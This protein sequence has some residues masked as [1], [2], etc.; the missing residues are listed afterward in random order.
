MKQT[1]HKLAQVAG[2]LALLLGMSQPAQAVIDGIT[3]PTFNLKAAPGYISTA[4]GNNQ[5]V[6]GFADA[7]GTVAMQYPGPT[8]IVNQGDTVIVNLQNALPVPVSIL[9]PGQSN[10]ISSTN[11][12]SQ[13]GLVTREAALGGSVSYSFV[14]TEPGTYMYHSATQQALQLEMGLVGALIVRPNVAEPLRQAYSHVNTSFDYEYLFLLTEMDPAI[15]AQVEQQALPGGILFQMQELGSQN[16]GLQTQLVQAD[17]AI[18]AKLSEL[19]ATVPFSTAYFEVLGQLAP[20]INDQIALGVQ[21]SAAVDQLAVLEQQYLA[22]GVV[23]ISKP[24]PTLWFINGRNGPDTL[25]D[26]NVP[27]LPNQPYN[28]LPRMHPGEKLLMRVVS[29]GR[30][31][32]PFHT[33]GNNT[34]LIARDGRMLESAPGMGPDLASSNYTLTTVPGQTYDAT[35]EW[36]GKGL[37]WDIY[38]HAPGDPME[39]SEYGPDHGKAFPEISTGVPLM[40]PNVLDLAEGQ[41]Y[42]GSPFL[43]SKEAPRPGQ[44][45]TNAFGGYFHMWHSHNEK[46]LTND[47]IFPGGMLTLVI[48][49]PHGVD[50]P[51]TQS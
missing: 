13:A 10:V 37:N 16:A 35:Y 38:G 30:D 12:E 2:A 21:V 31:L 41:F 11:P 25:L 48:I 18:N 4:D 1:I 6:W 22:G 19:A 23:D 34:W 42:S 40:L 27:W 24:F 47:D 14:A 3:G 29:A 36:T 44:A 45:K 50:I 28:I 15:H 20:L 49:E 8:L 7:D 33:H 39:P 51:D 32:H 5:Y 17:A 9:F 26:A 43:G 46:E